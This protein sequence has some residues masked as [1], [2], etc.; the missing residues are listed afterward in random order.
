[1]AGEVGLPAPAAADDRDPVHGT[2][3]YRPASLR[4]RRT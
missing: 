3:V 4:R 1:L 2:A